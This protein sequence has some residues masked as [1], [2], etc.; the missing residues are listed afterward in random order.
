MNKY[1]LD[2][3][4]ARF[5]NRN[6]GFTLIELLV[7]IA[8]I[9]ILAAML[10]PALSKAKEKAQGIA[11]M[12][13]EKQLVLAA[14]M[15]ADDNHDNWLPN[16]PG[17]SPGWVAGNM[18]WTASNTDNTNS[19]MLVDPKVSVI[20]PYIKN[21]QIFH[22]PADNSTVAG[23]GPRVRSVSMSQ[24]VGTVYTSTGYLKAGD[25]VNGQWT[26]GTDIGAVPQSTWRTFG[27]TSSM[28][29]PVPSDL[30][31][32]CDEHPDSINDAQMAVEMAKTGPSGYYVD[33]PA[34]YHDGG[35]GY[36]FADGHAEIHHWMGKKIQPPI[37]VGGSIGNGQSLNIVGNSQPDISDLTWL[38]EHTSSHT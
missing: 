24:T 7:V 1:Y 12:N 4:E 17:Q 6:G 19:D 15:Y 14:I 27:K 13:N 11:C 29:D 16:F 8:I 21:P 38:Q 9:A 26:S 37:T 23:E 3:K 28:V 25:A 33:F 5:A 2:M 18:N 36:S 32:F 30:W 35:A 20:G 31:V 10:L 34:S 22:C